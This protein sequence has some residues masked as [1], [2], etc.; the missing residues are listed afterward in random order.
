[1]TTKHLDH[2]TSNL[3]YL[4]L[5]N[6]TALTKREV[7]GLMNA[8]L[9]H[10]S[11]QNA[12][13]WHWLFKKTNDPQDELEFRTLVGS[14]SQRK[15]AFLALTLIDGPPSE[16]IPP[17]GSKRFINVW[18]QAEN[19]L[20]VAALS[21]LSSC[22]SS[23]DIG[24]IDKLLDASA[25]DVSRAA[26]FA[27]ATILARNSIYDALT[28][29][30]SREDAEVPA[31]LAVKLLAAPPVLE[32]N[33]LRKCLTNRSTVFRR[34]V[35]IE[36]LRRNAIDV[37]D[38]KALAQSIDPETRGLA[39]RALSRKLL[40]FSLSDARAI[41]VKPQKQAGL[42]FSE[43]RDFPGEDEFENY[44]HEILCQ[45]S[46][47]ELRGR[48]DGEGLY[49]HDISFALY[50]KYFK[51][52][53][54]EFIDNIEDNFVSFIKNKRL[55]TQITEVSTSEARLDEFVR[56]RMLQKAISLLC[57]KNVKK[58]LT[59][60]RKKIDE[61]S[62]YYSEELLNY[63][64][65]FGNWDDVSRVVVLVQNVNKRG[66]SI[67]TYFAQREEYEASAKAVVAL[68]RE[69]VGDLLAMEM[70]EGLRSA[71]IRELPQKTFRSLDNNQIV[72][73]LRS[74][75]DGV[76]KCIALKAVSCLTKKRIEII[77]DEYTNRGERYFYNA[78][79]WLDLGAN[80]DKVTSYH[81]AQR[82]LALS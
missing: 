58:H 27:K 62:L 11:S 66:L 4:N 48:V 68:G 46:L 37:D 39:A 47:S 12:P 70:P 22:G 36:L 23:A 9:E 52:M 34:M 6:S 69:R 50:D 20:V 63:L 74:S 64:K 38:A 8:G 13:L 75:S 25:T 53:E 79:F 28:F 65:K 55:K 5:R 42:A 80:S 72:T 49:S 14:S 77:M 33:L 82:E 30:S 43:S 21:Y 78:V 7:I 10:F 2:T 16:R 44:K 26:V 1:M 71:V 57:S 76:R 15:N 29:I 54:K 18:L 51:Q 31:S 61:N 40:E 45:R 32:T 67:L 56:G 81:A 41:V 60:I 35:A 19:D 17:R 24:Q 73:W 3:M 59:L